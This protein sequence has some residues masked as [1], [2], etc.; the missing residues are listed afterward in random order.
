MKNQ[1]DR[2]L[3]WLKQHRAITT[4]G[5]I[6]QLAIYRVSERIRE[7]LAEGHDIS[8]ERI[9]VHNKYGEECRVARYRLIKAVA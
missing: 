9:T 2:L 8:R 6:E 3:S 5:A 1:R 4:K 7:L